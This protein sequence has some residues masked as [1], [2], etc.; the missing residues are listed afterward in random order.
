MAS[1][2]IIDDEE[3][4]RKLLKRLLTLEAFEVE[5]AGSLQAG[6]AVLQHK[7][8]DV[9][10]CDVKLPDGSGVDFV[11]KIKARFPLLECILLTAYGNIPDGVQ[12]IKNGAFDYITKGNDNDRIIPL[13]HQAIDKA[14]QNRK[15]ALRMD[16]GNALRFEDI[17]GQSPLILEAIHL[18]RKIALTHHNVLLTGETG[19][20]KEVFAAAIHAGSKNPGKPF[21]AV[22]CSAFPRDLLEGELFGHKAGAY[23]GAQKDKKGILQLADKGILFLDE[24]GEMHPELQAKLLRVLETGRYIRLGDEQETQVSVRII[25]ATNRDLLAESEAG[26]FRADLYYRINGFNIH[27]PALRER[28]EDIPLLAAHFLTAY[29]EK[30]HLP[31]P[32]L[33]PDSL[34]LLQQYSWKGNIRELKNVIERAAVLSDTGIILPMHLP[35]VIQQQDVQSANGL[36]L[37]AVEKN[38]IAQVL[39][40]TKGN[41]TRAA[42]LLGIGLST[43]YRKIEE[44]QVH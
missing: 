3:P 4:L 44:Y 43:L 7:T 25:A 38:H 6:L 39:Q 29:A 10:L 34:Q 33:H 35:Y 26:R 41:K 5:E 2:L 12:A 21:I 23:T 17:I 27:L 13:L 8:I 16:A 9:L 22:N 30:E 19:T 31:L 36:S 20:G 18:A 11:K 24:I 1:I 40:Y 15:K 28:A 32:V 37:A 42:E 14:V